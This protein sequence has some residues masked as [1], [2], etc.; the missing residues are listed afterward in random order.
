MLQTWHFI[1]VDVSV[2]LTLKLYFL[3]TYNCTKIIRESSWWPEWMELLNRTWMFRNDFW[4][5]STSEVLL[6]EFTF[7]TPAAQISFFVLWKLALT[8][9]KDKRCV[10]TSIKC[11]L[12][13]LVSQSIHMSCLKKRTNATFIHF[14]CFFCPSCYINVKR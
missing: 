7:C 6:L 12:S 9:T 13:A 14:F 2:S 1:K 5:L 4:V 10:C 3:T 8:V 11:E